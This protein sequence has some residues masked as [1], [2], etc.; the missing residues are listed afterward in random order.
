MAL[1]ARTINKHKLF[2]FIVLSEM[3][4]GRKYSSLVFLFCSVL[5]RLVGTDLVS[6]RETTWDLQGRTIQSLF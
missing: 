3:A 1:Y 4:P 5:L 6:R 2:A